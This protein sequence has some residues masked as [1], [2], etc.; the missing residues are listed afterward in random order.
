MFPYMVAELKKKLNCQ[1][2]SKPGS[3]TT[4]Q[5]APVSLLHSSFL[6]KEAA[7]ATTR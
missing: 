3:V 5:K 2:L 6:S 7:S 4:V 1:A